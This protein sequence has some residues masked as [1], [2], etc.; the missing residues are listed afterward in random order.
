MRL[1]KLVLLGFLY[2]C[3]SST[4]ANFAGTYNTT[5]VEGANDC[6]LANWTQGSSAANIQVQ[7][8]QDASTAQL[9]V[10]GLVGTYLQLVLGTKSFPGTVNG[11]V[12]TAN[13]LGPA[14][15][16]GNC[17]SSTNITISVT[18]DGNNNLSGTITLTPKTNAD[19]SCGVLN[20]C[21]NQDVVTGAR[22][23][24]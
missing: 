9:T 6:N 5:F 14:T 16:N 17:T 18:I 20:T 11:N 19:A 7:F 22:T 23:G 13:Y 1:P 10:N 12:F 2:A 21:S 15:T 3:S 24:P 4:P 8:T